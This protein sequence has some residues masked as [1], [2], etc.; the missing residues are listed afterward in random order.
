M[1]SWIFE[2]VTETR[3]QLTKQSVKSIKIPCWMT[4]VELSDWINP[5]S[6]HQESSMTIGVI[7]LSKSPPDEKS[8]WSRSVASEPGTIRF[9]GAMSVTVA[10]LNPLTEAWKPLLMGCSFACQVLAL[11]S[12]FVTARQEFTNDEPGNFV[13][14][15]GN[16]NPLSRRQPVAT[17]IP[18]ILG[19][20]EFWVSLKVLLTY[21][22]SRGLTISRF[23]LDSNQFAPKSSGIES[24]SRS[25][26]K[27]S[28]RILWRN[29]LCD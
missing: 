29:D 5:A 12:A 26:W 21:A 3:S 17:Q 4:V 9:D 18:C 8:Y 19:L 20:T 13:T 16:L 10:I 24:D 27:S 25:Q 7:W 15:F 2:P 11:M 28:E 14:R 22:R 23:L 1:L 6:A